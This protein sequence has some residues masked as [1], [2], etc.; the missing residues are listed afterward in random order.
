MT[1]RVWFISWREIGELC[2]SDRCNTHPL[3][4]H[5]A[6]RESYQLGTLPFLDAIVPLSANLLPSPVLFTDIIPA[7]EW[8]VAIDDAEEKQEKLDALHGRSK[9]NRKTGRLMRLSALVSSSMPGYVRQMPG[10]ED[11]GDE[12]LEAV[13][14]GRLDHSVFEVDCSD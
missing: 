14:R 10:A 1:K 2:I 6:C 8:M 9:I 5:A 4:S 11:M 7:I 13:R 12:G 3:M